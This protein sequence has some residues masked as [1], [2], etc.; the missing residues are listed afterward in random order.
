MEWIEKLRWGRDGLMPV[1][2]ADHATRRPL[3]LC[4]MD[5]EALRATIQTGKVHT[6]SRSRGRMALKGESSGHF[7]FVKRLLVNCN[8]D[9]LCVEVEQKVAACHA[10]YFSCFYREIDPRTGERRAVE[11]RLFDP[12]AVYRK[13]RA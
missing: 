8:E 12:D 5:R 11:E 13:G 3:V 7:Q 2:V 4:F 10:G 6:Y 1:V 9:S